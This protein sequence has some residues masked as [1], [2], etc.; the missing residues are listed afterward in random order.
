MSAMYSAFL[1]VIIAAGA[2]PLL[3]ALSLAFSA[4]FCF[5]NALRSG[6]GSRLFGAGYIP[7]SNGGQSASSCRLF[8]L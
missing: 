4:T 1:A 8:I 3:A 2:P 6:S 5:D 7:Q